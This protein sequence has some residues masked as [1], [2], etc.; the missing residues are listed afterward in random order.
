MTLRFWVPEACR[1]STTTFNGSLLHEGMPAGRKAVTHRLVMLLLAGSTAYAQQR[2]QGAEGENGLTTQ[3][4]EEGSGSAL[5]RFS[6]RD[7]PDFSASWLP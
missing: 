6:A 2:E 4:N 7:S 5:V 3:S 1:S